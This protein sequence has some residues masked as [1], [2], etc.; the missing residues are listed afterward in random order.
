MVLRC[1][2][3]LRSQAAAMPLHTCMHPWGKHVD[4][5]LLLQG[6]LAAEAD[7][8]ARNVEDFERS[9]RDVCA[10]AGVQPTDGACGMLA[11][12]VRCLLASKCSAVLHRVQGDLAR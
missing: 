7:A 3:L 9:L 2:Q 6:R 5:F 12:T 8:H 11:C 4:S 10:Q 1:L